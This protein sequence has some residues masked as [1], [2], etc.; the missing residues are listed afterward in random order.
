ML[1][2]QYLI[3]KNNT[4]NTSIADSEREKFLNFEVLYD[5]KLSCTV[6][7]N[8]EANTLLLGY[9][10]DPLKPELNNEQ[11]ITSLSES[12]DNIDTLIKNLQKYSGRYVL[13]Y[14]N[15]KNFI[16]LSD[17]FGLRQIYYSAYKNSFVMSS[18]PKMILNF[19]DMCS[20]KFQQKYHSCLILMITKP[21]KARGLVNIDMINELEKHF[22]IISLMY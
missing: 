10:L 14:S 15:G 9:I 4:N 6:A 8:R 13:L 19:L 7:S 20:P 3:F 21:V 17:A 11:I 1:G 12:S 16:A 22:L 18:S 2:N 5:Q